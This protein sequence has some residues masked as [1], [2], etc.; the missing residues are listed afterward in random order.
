MIITQYI[1]ESKKLDWKGCLMLSMPGDIARM[2]GAFSRSRIAD[3]DLADDGRE[4]YCHCTILYG[5]GQGEEFDDISDVV[6]QHSSLTL[7]LGKIK[8]FVA[9]EHRPDSDCIV[10]EVEASPE[11]R[12]LHVE[13]KDIFK[14]TTNYPTYNPHVTIAYV[15]PGSLT[16]L[17]GDETF[18]DL[19][20]SC[21]K[22]TYSTG[23]SEN[24]SRKKLTFEEFQ[25]KSQGSC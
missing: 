22:M 19:E 16:E 17:D 7:K 15:K 20:V 2:V 1:S 4:D 24:R 3:V 13:L 10:I 11:L 25:N 8:R 6:K 9:N 18:A 14:V 5:F 21:D 23:N 12:D